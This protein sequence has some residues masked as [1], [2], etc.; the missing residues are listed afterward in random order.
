MDLADWSRS[1]PAVWWLLRQVWEA[2][3]Q[4]VRVP[5]GAG[6]VVPASSQS[7]SWPAASNTAPATTA[8]AQ[9]QPLY[10]AHQGRTLQLLHVMARVRCIMHVCSP[11]QPPGWQ[12]Q[13]K[14]FVETVLISR[15]FVQRTNALYFYWEKHPKLLVIDGG[16]VV[17]RFSNWL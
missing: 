1:A 6:A 17:L 13:W 15:Y 9:H 3:V 12:L 4:C 11:P 7:V 14:I 16:K 10:A 8:A 2:S 5:A